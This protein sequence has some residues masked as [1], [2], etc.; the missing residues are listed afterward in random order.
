VSVVG[1]SNRTRYGD[2]VASAE[3]R[4]LMGN[5]PNIEQRRRTPRR[6]H[7]LI[8][9]VVGFGVEAMAVALAITQRAWV[10]VGLFA[11][12]GL[13][14][15]LTGFRIAREDLPHTFMTALLAPRSKEPPS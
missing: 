2:A 13:G 15:L 11:L 12:F 8:W 4:C 3:V 14:M 6:A 10:A 5:S 9:Y 7:S 1:D